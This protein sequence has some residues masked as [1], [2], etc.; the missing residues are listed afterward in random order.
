MRKSGED[1]DPPPQIVGNRRLMRTLGAILFIGAPV[2]VEG[3]WVVASWWR[4]IL[5]FGP[6]PGFKTPCMTFL[7]SVMGF[8]SSQAGDVWGEMRSSVFSNPSQGVAIFL[9]VATG[10]VLLMRRTAGR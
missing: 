6:L 3:A 9:M 2:W 5:G 4:P 1:Y 10:C 7:K 8:G